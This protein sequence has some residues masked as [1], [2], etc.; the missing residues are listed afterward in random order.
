MNKYLPEELRNLNAN[1]ARVMNNVEMAIE[2]KKKRHF[3]VII[4]TTLLTAALLVISLIALPD[5]VRQ[6]AHD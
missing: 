1:K 3:P 6:N 2:K 5:R 4:A